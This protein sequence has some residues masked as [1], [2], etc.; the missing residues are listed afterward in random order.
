MDQAVRKD[1]FLH[2]IEVFQCGY[3]ADDVG[4][5]FTCSEVDALASVFEALDR[6]DVAAKW[7]AG[8]AE[9]DEEGDTHHIPG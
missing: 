5:H 2:F 8:H 7:I 6:P 3:L 9:T 1:A 4:P